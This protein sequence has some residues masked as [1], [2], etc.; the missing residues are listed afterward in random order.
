MRPTRD[1]AMREPVAECRVAAVHAD[2]R[3]ADQR[4]IEENRDEIG[5]HVED[6][7]HEGEAGGG[8][9]SGG[10]SIE[11]AKRHRGGN[12]AADQQHQRHDREHGKPEKFLV[13]PDDG[14]GCP[15]QRQAACETTC[16]DIALVFLREGALVAVARP[17]AQGQAGVAAGSDVLDAA[18]AR[19]GSDNRLG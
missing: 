11:G 12:E 4:G 13:C 5:E 6:E 8:I 17:A 1:L 15:G 10:R 14:P 19:A 7:R 2:H 9:T 16:H 3:G 18:D